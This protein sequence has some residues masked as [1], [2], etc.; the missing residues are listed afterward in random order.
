MDNIQRRLAAFAPAL[1]KHPLLST[2]LVSTLTLLLTLAIKDYNRYLSLGP[3]G[4]PYN[5]WGWLFIT[6]F[7]RPFTISRKN[8]TNVSEY[9]STGADPVITSLPRR[10]GPRP[11]VGEIAPQR[12]LTQNIS[13][14]MQTKL[15]EVFDDVLAKNGDII[16]RRL[17]HYEKHNPALYVNSTLMESGSLQIP[18][19]ARVAQGEIGHIHPD[20]SFHLYLSPADARVVIEK[21]WAEK[22]RLATQSWL[23]G[24]KEG[25]FGVM[26]TYLLFYGPRG[27]GE[28]EVM[29]KILRRGVEWMTGRE[30]SE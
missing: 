26:P 16:E 27:E 10:H 11:D 7:L 24:G 5:I 4:L 28:A 2:S 20:G 12:Q 14:T 3:G 1:R 15:Q 25:V 29:G 23:L 9:P 30:V 22:H 8:T 18:F 19:T 17:S 6:I 13:K 21:G